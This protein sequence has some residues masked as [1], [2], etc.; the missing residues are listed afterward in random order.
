MIKYKRITHP[1]ANKGFSR[2]RRFVGHF[3]FSCNRIDY[4]PHSNTGHSVPGSRTL[5]K[6][7]SECC[8]AVI[9]MESED[10]G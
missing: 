6:E 3:K 9:K 4:P 8:N 5:A 10:V 1:I 7:S 2:M